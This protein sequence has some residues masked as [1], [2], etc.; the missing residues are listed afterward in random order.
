MYEG[1]SFVG[2]VD[3]E[4]YEGTSCATGGAECGAD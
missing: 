3:D 4:V 1:T 2:P